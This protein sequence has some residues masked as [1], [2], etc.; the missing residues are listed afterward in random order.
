MS[1]VKSK[2]QKGDRL[3]YTD[4]EVVTIPVKFNNCEFPNNG[5]KYNVIE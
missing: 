4:D 5:L 1:E 3:F 2:Y